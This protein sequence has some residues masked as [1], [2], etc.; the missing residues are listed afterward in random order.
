[1]NNAYTRFVYVPS[2]LKVETYT[3]IQEGLGESPSFRITDG[4]GRVIA[5]AN[6]HPGSTGGFSG[7]RI[8]YDVMGRVFKTSNPTETSAS[9]TPFQWN[10][11][12]D[13]SAAGWI[14]S[15]QT[16][17]WK[18]RPLVTTNPSVTSNP[19][20]TTTT[21]ASY[22]GCGCAGG[23]VTTLTDEGTKVGADTKKRQRK[24]YTDVLGRIVKNE[25]LN[26]DGSGP[27]GTGG[28][29]YTTTTTTYNVRDQVLL[30]RE[31][32]GTSSSTTFRDTTMSYDGFGRL[33]T[34]HSPGQKIDPNNGASSDHTTWNY[35]SDN[36]V[37][38]V[39]DARGVITSFSYNARHLVTAVTYDSSNVPI[40]ANVVATAS[41]A[42]AYDA[43]GNR[44]SMSDGS[45]AVIYHYD[46]L[47][48]MDWEERTFAGLPTAGT[49]RLS[50]EYNLGGVLKKITDERADT[51]FTETLNRTGR[52][53]AVNAVGYQGA[54]TQF[55][56]QVQ[57]RAGGQLKSR[58]QGNVT[59]SFDYNNRG[60]VKS[61]ALVGWVN[62]PNEYHFVNA[63]YQYHHDGTIKLA[64]NGNP[65]KDRAYSYDVAARLQTAYSGVEARE[66]VNNTSGG[67]PDGPYRHS[68]TYDQWDNQ[69]SVDSSFWS[70]GGE[71]FLEYDANNRVP[72]WS[73]DAEGNVL[74]R[75]ETAT[76]SPFEPG[77]YSY[78]A[79]GREIG[80]TQKRS[81]FNIEEGV[82]YVLTNDFVNTQKHDGDGQ[83]V[84]YSVL[85]H[86]YV[87]THFSSTVGGRV[88]LLRS[89][90]L[91]GRAIS[92]Y[93]ANGAWSS[94]HVF[95]GNE[96]IGQVGPT[97][98]GGGLWHNFDPVT[99]DLMS[100]VSNGSP[101][102]LDDA[103]YRRRKRRRL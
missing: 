12:G 35:N 66:F 94:T 63:S 33:K 42:L 79:A 51:S 47:S 52:V 10:A 77:R 72:T 22:T 28:T 1:M 102:I 24:I 39:V 64:Q 9:G 96:R 31:F 43:V 75:N 17:D 36:T 11:T 58:S 81:T 8:V 45:G 74:S 38:S 15:E 76:F 84:D 20:E 87:N 29:V 85:R 27:N 70:R 50:Y 30:L 97:V 21:T 90:V 6:D 53:T 4:A 78:D 91:A 48:R 59:A 40:G 65:I 54:Q 80:S 44:T 82:G 93:D 62:T 86:M 5:T 26:W 7:R 25:I 49:F 41:V 103:R 34:Q 88:F 89:T 14:Y 2:Q 46:Q 61:Y 37:Q 98:P 99:G 23:E 101:S 67:T 56:S 60:L 71:T 83:V 69:S 57:Y 3:T 18:G 13:D 73:Y 100:T 16:Y 19:A 68:Y 92:E 55:A 32:A 95:A